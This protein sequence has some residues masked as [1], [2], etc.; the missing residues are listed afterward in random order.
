VSATVPDELF[1]VVGQVQVRL[2]RSHD[3]SEPAFFRVV[4]ETAIT[5]A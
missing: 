4:D 2:V 1:G 3:A 5:T